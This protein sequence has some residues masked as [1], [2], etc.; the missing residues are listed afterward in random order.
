[1]TGKYKP[2]TPTEGERHFV[3][4]AIPK[5]G[6]YPENT[7][8]EIRY[9]P[10]RLTGEKIRPETYEVKVGKEFRDDPR[11]DLKFGDVARETSNHLILHLHKED[12]YVEN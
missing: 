3:H 7:E 4:V 2:F 11:F 5:A 9:I 10:A 1:M 8:G 12:I 6:E